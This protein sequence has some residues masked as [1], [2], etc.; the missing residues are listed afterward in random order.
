MIA[1]MDAASDVGSCCSLARTDSIMLKVKSLGSDIMLPYLPPLDNMVF[2]K[3]IACEVCK[4]KSSEPSPFRALPGLLAGVQGFD[5][6]CWPFA[7]PTSSPTARKCLLC[8]WVH[9]IAGYSEPLKD[10]M[11]VM[12]QNFDKTAEFLS[13]LRHLVQL[14]IE[15]KVKVGMRYCS[16]LT[17]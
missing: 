17:T 7:G 6:P 9:K 10:L 8:P 12:G 1:S 5:G 15:G 11:K 4:H 16:L 14:I 13:C 3:I 2:L